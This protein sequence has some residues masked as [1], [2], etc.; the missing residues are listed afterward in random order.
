MNYHY[1][2]NNKYHQNQQWTTENNPQE[3]AQKLGKNMM[4]DQIEEVI[5]PL[6]DSEAIASW[7]NWAFLDKI[8]ELS[9][10][11]TAY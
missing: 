5:R 8:T 10:N 6:R 3:R 2:D 9:F 11:W 4:F 7:R 1:I